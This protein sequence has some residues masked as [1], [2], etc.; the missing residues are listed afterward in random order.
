MEHAQKIKFLKSTLKIMDFIIPW[1]SHG[2][3]ASLTIEGEKGLGAVQSG[4][5]CARVGCLLKCQKAHGI[6]FAG[7][8]W[9]DLSPK[10]PTRGF[11][12]KK[13]TMWRDLSAIFPNLKA[14]GPTRGFSAKKEGVWRD[15]SAIL[16]RGFSAKREIVWRDLWALPFWLADFRRKRKRCGAPSKYHYL[17]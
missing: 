13:E 14:K 6:P 12:A 16:T 1:Q 17:N 4:G 9:R 7:R 2:S 11:S 3:Y 10:V 8:M 15:L 5:G